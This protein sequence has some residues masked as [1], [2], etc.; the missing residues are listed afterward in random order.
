MLEITNIP[1]SPCI[2]NHSYDTSSSSQNHVPFPVE[3]ALRFLHTPVA[4]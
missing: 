4:F 3:S 1:V 2:R